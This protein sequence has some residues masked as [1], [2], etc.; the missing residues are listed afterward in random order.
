MLAAMRGL[1]QTECFELNANDTG[2]ANMLRF[3]RYIAYHG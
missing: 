3:S 2:K 1:T